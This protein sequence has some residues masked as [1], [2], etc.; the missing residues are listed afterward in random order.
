MFIF[1][2]HVLGLIHNKHLTKSDTSKQYRGIDGKFIQIWFIYVFRKYPDPIYSHTQDGTV[3]SG[4]VRDV[5]YAIEAGA[6][7][8]IVD[9][10]LGY[11]VRMD[12]L[13]VSFDRKI[14]AGQSLWHISE[15]MNGP[16]LVSHEKRSSIR[17]HINLTNGF[18]SCVMSIYL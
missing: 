15:R 17:E 5:I 18:K 2:Y 1:E 10:Q 8:R 13:E 12:N 16:N 3:I 11:G 4:S 7:M 14:A 9:R 6:D